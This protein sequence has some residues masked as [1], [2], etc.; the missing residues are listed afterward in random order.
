M[1]MKKEIF[2]YFCLLLLYFIASCNNAE[3][4]T[5]TTTGGADTAVTVTDLPKPDNTLVGADTVKTV[6]DKVR[7][8]TATTRP[9][10]TPAPIEPAI[11]KQQ[12]LHYVIDTSGIKKITVTD[13][14]KKVSDKITDINI[15]VINISKLKEEGVV[16]WQLPQ[17]MRT[18]EESLVIVRIATAANEAPVKK[19]MDTANKNSGSEE[20]DITEKMKVSLVAGK[21]GD[22]IIVAKD[23]IHTIPDKKYAEW[24]WTVTPLKAGTRYLILKVSQV[25]IIDGKETVLEENAVFSKE[26]KVKVS[27]AYVA[28][29]I[30][31]FIK[32]NWAIIT[33]IITFFAGLFVRK[34]IIDTKKTVGSGQ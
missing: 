11:K 2:A 30:W 1:F 24:F 32:S 14:A 19:G 27:A 15:P 21:D 6:K 20:I 18:L 3:L 7:A 8:D 23:S 10:I 13:R 12:H 4:K 34:K 22:F 28:A 9:V 16:V 17:T 26:F 31:D 33:A 29:Q 25:N 5:D